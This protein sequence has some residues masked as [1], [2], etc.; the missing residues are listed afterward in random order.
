V[1][2]GQPVGGGTSL[3]TPIWVGFTALIDQYLGSHGGHPV[4]FFN[5]LLYPL[6]NSAP[7]YPPFNDIIVGGNDFYPAGTG[8]DMTTGL[9]SPN[10][11]NLARDLA[12]QKA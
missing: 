8:Y 11:Y 10:V 6:A 7:P 2:N 3:A 12:A 5:P 4:G 9:G 1:N